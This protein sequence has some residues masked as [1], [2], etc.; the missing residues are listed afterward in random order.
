MEKKNFQEKEKSKDVRLNNIIQAKAVADSIRTSLGPKGMDKMIQ[1]KKNE[2]LITNDGA[3]I[4]AKM[5]VVHPTAKMLVDVSKSQD[6]EVGDGTTSVVVIAG[7]LLQ[8]SQDLLN[9]AEKMAQKFLRDMGIDVNFNDRDSLLK[10]SN[11]SLNSKVVSQHSEI[12]SPMAVDAI[13]KITDPEKDKTV[14][15]ND[16]K[17]VKKL[18]GTLEDVELVDGIVFTQ[19]VMRSAGG[20]SRIENAKIGL[21]QFQLSSPKTDATHEIGIK[22]YQ[23]IDRFFKEERKYILQMC[24][25]IQKTGCNVLLIQK[26][27]LRDAISDLALQILAKM[28]ILVIK[29]I[30]RSEIEF[31]SK[32]L[33]CLP[34]ASIESFVPEKLGHAKL[35]EESSTADGKI[36]KITGVANPGK[37]VSI[38]LRGSNNLILDEAE[39]SLHDALC[40]IRSIVKERKLLPGGGAP[41]I[42][43]SMKLANWA[44]EQSGVESVCIRAYAEALEII[45]YTLAENAGLHPISIVTELRNKHLQGQTS[46]GINI[47]TGQVGDILEENVVQ[48]LL[49]TSSALSLATETVVMILKID[50]II[51]AR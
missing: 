36:V 46:A 43:V 11:T 35:V 7:S 31:V 8:A 5:E 22:E 13:L 14:D 38:I 18:G 34:I 9:R 25:K 49:V 30:E 40:V 15:L 16:I 39:R 33:G 17:I 2:V 50:D 29:D 51:G 1:D 6:I 3:T 23:A 47:R 27:I 20:P 19:R 28:K 26:S 44:K 42:E 10:S 21:I 41:E 48:P 12:L 45:P 32:T 37:T 24:A 4:L